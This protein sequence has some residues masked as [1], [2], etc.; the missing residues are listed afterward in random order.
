MAAGGTGLIQPF[1]LTFTAQ[2]HQ[3]DVMGHVNN[4]VWVQWMEAIA[5]A[6]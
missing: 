1:S 2:A 3:I 5:T 4:A 6:H